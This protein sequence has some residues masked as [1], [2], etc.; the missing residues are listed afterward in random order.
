MFK[1]ASEK[2]KLKTMV[3]VERD[4]TI[5]IQDGK[6]KDAN[7]FIIGYP[8]LLAIEQYGQKTGCTFQITEEKNTHET[9]QFTNTHIFMRGETVT[10]LVKSTQTKDS[11]NN[12]GRDVALTIESR[13]P[14]DMLEFLKK[15]FDISGA[16]LDKRSG[17]QHKA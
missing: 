2:N 4:G 7:D 14:N 8:M 5:H 15:N 11:F 13:D 3:T 12:D 17:L 16:I 9:M 1:K 10:M 6:I